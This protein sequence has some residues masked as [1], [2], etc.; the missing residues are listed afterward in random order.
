MEMSIKHIKMIK[1]A[2]ESHVNIL[3]AEDK[4]PIPMEEHQ[5]EIRAYVDLLEQIEI[6]LLKQ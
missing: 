6:V 2:L 1:I 4:P 5:A 3:A